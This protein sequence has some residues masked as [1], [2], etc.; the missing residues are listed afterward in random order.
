MLYLH[1][2]FTID[3]CEEE[4]VG[5]KAFHHLQFCSLQFLLQV[6]FAFTGLFIC[7]RGVAG[8]RREGL[9]LPVEL[10]GLLGKLTSWWVG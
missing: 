4:G 10:G 3:P 8:H 5:G 6:S 1:C 7:I 2:V 9:R